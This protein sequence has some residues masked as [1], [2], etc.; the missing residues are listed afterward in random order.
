M[1]TEA[2]LRANRANSLKST[3]PRS[4]EGKAASRFNALKHG[5]DAASVVLPGE[6]PAAYEFM[7]ATYDD[8]LQP[9]TPTERFH[10]DTMIQANWQKQRL[11]RVESD[12]YRDLIRQS[13][14]TSL[15]TALQAETP[16]AKV[17]NRVQRQLAACE[18]DW[19]RASRELRRQREQPAGAEATATR[20]NTVEPPPEPAPEPLYPQRELASFPK[21]EDPA[22]NDCA[23]PSRIIQYPIRRQS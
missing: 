10:V 3:G 2:Q 15:A 14:A 19:H 1:A 7:V 13:G 22:G 11:L 20:R 4:V 8:E 16:A 9:Q 23:T 6:N 17:L 18:R 12:L 21:F 5:M